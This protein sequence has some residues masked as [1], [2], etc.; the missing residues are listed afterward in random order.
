M[1]ELLEVTQKVPTDPVQIDPDIYK[2]TMQD[3]ASVVH[4]KAATKLQEPPSLLFFIGV[5]L[6]LLVI[7]WIIA[8]M[9]NWNEI[10]NNWDKYKCNPAITPFAKFYGYDLDETMKFCVGEAVKQNAPGVIVPLY[11][12]IDKIA[13]TVGGVYDKAAAI[14]GGVTKLLGGFE[15]FLTNF[16]NSF[17]LIGTRIRISLVKIRDIFDK[18]FS[19][20]TAF[21]MAGITAITF[22][23]NLMCNPLVTFIGTIAGVDVCCFAPDTLI[24]MQN[25]YRAFIRSVKIG[26]ILA[27]GSTVTSTFV[28]DGAKTEMVYLRGVHVSSNHSLIGPGGIFV[29]AGKHPLAVDAPC[30]SR[31]YCLSTTSNRIP[32]LTG[33][34]LETLVFT[35]Y[36]ES[37][38]PEVIREAQAAAEKALNGYT[39]AAYIP[40]FS[41]GI[42]PAASLEMRHGFKP[43]SIVTIGDRLKFGKVIGIVSESCK[44][45]IRT[46][47]GLILAAAQLVY[48]GSW[49][50]AGHL[51]PPY[52]GE[53]VLRHVFTDSTESI[54][55]QHNGETI[56]TRDYMEVHVREIQSPYD[57][58]IKNLKVAHNHVKLNNV[59][60]YQEQLDD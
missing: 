25:G 57:N 24:S 35:D 20:F 27:D 60:G 18:L 36:E 30:L 6:V 48:N 33:D 5:T 17:R 28:F 9:A 37:C 23:S 22:G 55:I 12:G 41:L 45:C 34:R 56:Q 50:R 8:E 38:E 59:Q 19:I 46:P 54:T 3:L 11:Q 2:A 58:H 49:V 21:T 29:E 16:A 32:V 14:Q 1:A 15:S 43:L 7:G 47:S 44:N 39:E 4:G 40:D 26:D 53:Y 42:D 52:R 51:Y 10:H 13:Q 31:L